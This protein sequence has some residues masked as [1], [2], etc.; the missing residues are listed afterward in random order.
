MGSFEGDLIESQSYVGRQ[1]S[2]ANFALLLHPKKHRLRINDTE[3]VYRN[4]KL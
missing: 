2:S 4:K 3:A 1:T